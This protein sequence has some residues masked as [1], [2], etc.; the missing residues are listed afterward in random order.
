MV[1]PIV[2]VSPIKWHL[3]HTTWFFENFILVPN[4]K[5]YQP[6]HPK[7]NY[8]FNSYYV[9]AGERWTRANRGQLTRP[10]VKEIFRYRQYVEEYLIAFMEK[11]QMPSEL[12]RIVELGIN[13]EQQHQELFLYDIKRI[14]GDNPLNPVYRISRKVKSVVPSK[15]WLGIEEGLHEI[16]HDGDS[17][18]FDNEKGKHQVFLHSFEI[19]SGLVT[20]AEYIEFMEADGYDSFQYWLHEAWDWVKNEGIKKPR[21][22]AEEEGEWWHYTLG[23]YEKVDPDDPVSHVSY[24]EADAFAR[25]KNCRLPTE[26]EWEVACKRFSPEIC[27]TSNFVESNVFKPIQSE[28]YGFFGNLWE[29]TSSPYVA[30]PFFKVAEGALGEYNGKFMVNQMVLRGGSFGTPR[31]HIRATYRNF[32]HPHLRWLFSG[33]RLAKHTK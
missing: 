4:L 30:Y 1:Q 26:Q 20:N 17:F 21:Y 25:W 31:N 19:E 7:F 2:D 28:D 10:T 6:F 13:H 12:L 18:H 29:W 15:E 22:W 27:N 11:E 3:G 5:G 14:L 16:G 24:Y 8:I 23:G 33:I 9:A 32:F